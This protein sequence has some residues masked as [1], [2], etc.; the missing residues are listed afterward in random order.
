MKNVWLGIVWHGFSAAFA[1]SVLA[2]PAL[3][4]R[5]AAAADLTMMV[6]PFCTP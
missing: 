2:V 1:L 3:G 5:L 4:S 6:E